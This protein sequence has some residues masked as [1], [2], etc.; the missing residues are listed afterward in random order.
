MILNYRKTV[1][2]SFLGKMVYIK[3]DRPIGYN[4]LYKKPLEIK[5]FFRS[6][7]TDQLKRILL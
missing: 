4:N 6:Y 2:K 5:H 3:I 1:A 7:T